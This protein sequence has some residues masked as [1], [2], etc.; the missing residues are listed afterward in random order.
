MTNYDNEAIRHLI[1][2]QFNSLCW[3]PNNSADWKMFAADFAPWAS[4][5][6]SARPAHPQTV[7]N[8]VER[9]KGLEETSLHTSLRLHWARWYMFSAMS[10]SRLLAAK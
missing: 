9:M 6:P 10:L 3:T 8:F 5:Y 2:R 1:A 7:E 4:L